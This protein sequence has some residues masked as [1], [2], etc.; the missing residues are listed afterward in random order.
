M[1]GIGED[2]KL[3][4]LCIADEQGFEVTYT[5]DGAFRILKWT[6]KRTRHTG[7]I[8]CGDGILLPTWTNGALELMGAMTFNDAKEW[9]RRK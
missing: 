5:K 7:L 3:E 6:P 2:K 9:L 4:L 8:I 1:R